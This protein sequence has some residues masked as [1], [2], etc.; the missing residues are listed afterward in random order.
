MDM[1]QTKKK[2]EE[3]LT[4]SFSKSVRIT[5]DQISLYSDFMNTHTH[6]TH[7]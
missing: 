4:F 6:K 5:A 2:I 1:L 3:N 7:T